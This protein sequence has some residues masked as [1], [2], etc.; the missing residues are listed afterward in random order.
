LA[1][2]RIDPNTSTAPRGRFT[3]ITLAQVDD[4]IEMTVN[5]LGIPTVLVNNA[6]GVFAAAMRDRTGSPED[7][8]VPR[9]Y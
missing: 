5:R 2:R 4:A 7:F 9:F 6:S 3:V 8:S 1:F